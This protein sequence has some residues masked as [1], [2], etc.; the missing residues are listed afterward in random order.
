MGANARKR[1]STVMHQLEDVRI[2]NVITKLPGVCLSQKHAQQAQTR[3]NKETNEL[4]TAR[5]T[6]CYG[7]C[8]NIML[9][10]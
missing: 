5:H 9:N 6:C 7:F 1:R 2:S 3:A 8:R 10:I 4:P